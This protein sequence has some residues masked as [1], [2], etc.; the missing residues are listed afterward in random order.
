MVLLMSLP[1]CRARTGDVGPEECKPTTATL[2]ANASADGL[3]G[4]Y[5]LTLVAD[6]GPREG[7]AVSGQLVLEPYEGQLRQRMRPDGSPD[8]STVYAAFGSTDIDL[9]KVGALEV[10]STK[11]RDPTRPGVLVMQRRPTS[12]GGAS[13]QITIRLGA[14]ANQRDRIRFD[15]GYTALYVREI[16]GDRLAG[17][18]GSGSGRSQVRGHFCAVRTQQP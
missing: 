1:G 6:D 9:T 4:E 7:E 8:P 18:W 11:S 12:A 13:T 5:R 2:S 17:E 15:G 14:D 16:S 3:T 10:G